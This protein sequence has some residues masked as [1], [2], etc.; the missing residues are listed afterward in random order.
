MDH[1]RLSRTFSNQLYIRHTLAN[2]HRS[3]MVFRVWCLQV[4]RREETDVELA[5]GSPDPN[6]TWEHDVLM[7][8]QFGGDDRIDPQSI[9]SARQNGTTC[10]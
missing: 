7:N 10:C 2:I 4:A 8:S 9:E 5:L 6:K 1:G 3:R